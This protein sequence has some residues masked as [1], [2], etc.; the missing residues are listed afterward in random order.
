MNLQVI[1]SYLQTKQH[2]LA[3]QVQNETL[4]QAYQLALDFKAAQLQGK[5]CARQFLLQMQAQMSDGYSVE[6][7]NQVFQ[8]MDA[9]FEMFAEDRESTLCKRP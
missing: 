4:Q 9:D 2:P 3:L 7:A 6:L 8:E 1:R 5:K